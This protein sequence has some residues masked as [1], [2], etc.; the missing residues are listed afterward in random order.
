[1][2]GIAGII[3]FDGAAI[4]TE[5]LAAMTDAMAHRGPD[6]IA[7][8]RRGSVALGQCMLRTTPESLQENQPLCNE[9]ESL[10][11][12]MD[13][14]VDNWQE[15]RRELL[16]HGAVLRDRSDAELVLRAYQAWGRECV[17]HI[18]GDFALVIW[19]ARRRRAF[20]A[21]DRL[22][23]KP[24]TYHWDGRTLAFASEL[25]AILV[26]PWVAQELNQGMVAEFITAEWYSRDETFWN[27]ILRLVAAHRLQAGAGGLHLDCYW[28]P[29][30]S[31]TL[32]CRQDEDYV[33]YYRELF[34]DTVRRKSRSHQPVACEVS[35]GLDSSAI[36]A[37]AEHL[38]RRQ[39]LPAPAIN[40]YVLDFEGDPQADELAYSRAVGD[41]LGVTIEE[42]PPTR[43]PLSWY[44]EWAGK[45]RE[46]P[47]YPNGVMQWGIRI[48]ARKRGSRVLLAGVGGDEW[49]C[50]NRSLY[51]EGLASGQWGDVYRAWRSD[52]AAAG[53]HSFWWLGRFGL[54]PLLPDSLQAILRHVAARARGR[55]R[56]DRHAC[57]TP[58]MRSL[59]AERREAYRRGSTEILAAKRHREDLATLVDPYSVLAREL[60]DRRSASAGIEQRA[61]FI[62]ARMI[63]FAF[64]APERLRLQGTLSKAL[65]RKALRGLLPEL[66]L[67]RT[68]KAEFST[69]IASHLREMEDELTQRIASQRA[70]WVPTL[71][72]GEIFAASA[73]AD[74]R[75]GTPAR[76]LWGL[77]GC[78]ALC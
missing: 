33:A 23:N 4:E 13:G 74:H 18:D 63:Q 10:V 49:L 37:M 32:P 43:K 2:S 19:D 48:E 35:G 8:W 40:G 38:R 30:P 45:Y 6:G 67:Q 55:Q 42:I 50:G 57:L 28:Q 46:F 9:D 27:G 11:L 31:I 54:L 70:D 78:D 26:L 76:T 52:F 58:A 14:R 7:H 3:R 12:V 36:F 17:T 66:V 39:Q 75:A 65:H 20:C 21:R 72:V 59:I 1:M 24:F 69:P 73:S 56:V 60:T 53:L 22:G 44:R 41:Y 71:V 16:G 61:P 34:A 29:D 51:A 68:S 64:S 77:F 62:D 25:H 5:L 15:L 47:G